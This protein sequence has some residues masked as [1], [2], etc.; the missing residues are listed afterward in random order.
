MMM[1]IVVMV[2]MGRE[3]YEEEYI[4]RQP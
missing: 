3:V 2:M 4:Q 1:I